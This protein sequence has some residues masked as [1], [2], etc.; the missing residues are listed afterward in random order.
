MSLHAVQPW[1][2]R[3]VAAAVAFVAAVLMVA[4]VVGSYYV[5]LRPTSTLGTER[6]AKDL[7]EFLL[8]LG[9]IG[10]VWGGGMGALFAYGIKGVLTKQRQRFPLFGPLTGLETMSFGVLGWVVMAVGIFIFV[11]T[12]ATG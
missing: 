10:G 8:L 9:P 2:F 4:L 5:N 11:L 6:D 3:L 12:V 1:R 7:Q